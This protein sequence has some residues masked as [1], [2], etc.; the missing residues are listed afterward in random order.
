[1][2]Y[3]T[4][5]TYVRY[6]LHLV[7]EFRWPLLVLGILILGGG[8]QLAISLRIPYSAACYTV[9]M[10]T[11][12]EPTRE[13]PSEWYNE[14][15]FVAVPV[16]GLGAI[17]DSIVRLG[18]LI[19]SSKRK[20]QEWWIMEAAA[21]R[22]HVVVCG[23]GKTG[24][25]IARELLQLREPFVL[26]EK[27]PEGEFVQEMLDEKIPVIFGDERHRRTLEKANV[28]KARAIIL[29]TDDDLANLDAALTAREMKPDI[30]VVMRLF[31]ETLARKMT[32]A[33]NLSAISTSQV[34]AP[35][36]VAAA[37]GR[38]VLHS[39]QLDGRTI[40]VADMQIAKLAGR[41]LPDLERD[42]EV[43]VVLHK[44][45]KV[46]DFNPRHERPVET[47]DTIVVMSTHEQIRRLE[48]ANRG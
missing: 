16:L 22:N 17:A 12:G 31:D 46:N 41:K 1:M 15:L 37:T 25:R 13:F 18:Y 7:R 20:L 30:R 32:A 10:L 43:S 2:P 3:R 39:F 11:L 9:F 40:H 45:P 38:N 34:S 14:I 21:Y 5:S 48:E 23:L 44:N 24:V 4:A 33:F 35:A 19:F 6:G 8:L 47:G 27:D 26:V 42:F 29:A 36:F 28:E